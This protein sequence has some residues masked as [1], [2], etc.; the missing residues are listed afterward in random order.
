MAS[1]SLDICWWRI[2]LMR[3]CTPPSCSRPLSSFLRSANFAELKVS[4]ARTG[5]LTRRACWVLLALGFAGVATLRTTIDRKGA[6]E[7]TTPAALYVSRADLLRK[8]SLGH[9][10]LLADIYWTRV[11]QYF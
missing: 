11:V 3:S 8:L 10:G 4:M 7:Q 9:E 1:R 2:L 5:S 6:A